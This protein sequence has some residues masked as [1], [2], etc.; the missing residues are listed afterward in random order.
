[1]KK[2]IAGVVLV[3]VIV[4]GMWWLQSPSPHSAVQPKVEITSNAASQ[5]V[6]LASAT[7]AAPD[8]GIKSS[9]GDFAHYVAL[10]KSLGE[11]PRSLQGTSVDGHLMADSNDNLI[12]S[13][14]V[15]FVF[16][17]FLS[18]MGEENIEQIKGRIA[19]YIKQ[20]LPTKA[21]SQTWGL[22]G[23]YLDYRHAASDVTLPSGL[24]NYERIKQGIAARSRLRR[25][26][27]GRE[28]ANAFYGPESA[29]DQ[30]TLKRMAIEQNAELT[31]SEKQQKLDTLTSQLPKAVKQIRQQTM[32]PTNVAQKVDAMQAAG[33][34]A[35]TIRQYRTEQFG[36]EA[37]ERLHALDKQRAAWQQRYQQYWDK[38]QSIVGAEL[39]KADQ[40]SQIAALRQR[41]FSSSEQKRVEALD[42]I[43]AQRSTSK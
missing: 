15:K 6:P 12:V 9:A 11:K 18:T 21:A 19:L 36:P 1:M 35:A 26:W 27:L 17:Y 41:L 43:A 5:T 20:Q 2:V 38:R 34:G 28:T 33:A 24:S 40:A 13:A 29:Y 42:S 3:V 14:Q 22:L 7:A 4:A 10:G 23:R 30:F 31:A 32:K 25:T 39:G 37:A 16:N 8:A